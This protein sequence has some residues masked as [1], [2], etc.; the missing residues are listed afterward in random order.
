[1]DGPQGLPVGGYAA[2]LGEK[3]GKIL[4]RKV[5]RKL[6]SNPSEF[7]SGLPAFLGVLERE[8]LK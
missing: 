7:L 1:L 3:A 4:S 8:S 5:T 6:S 2:S